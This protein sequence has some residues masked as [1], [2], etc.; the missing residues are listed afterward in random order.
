MEKFRTD[1][2]EGYTTQ[3]LEE[4]NDRLNE[5]LRKH[6]LAFYASVGANRNIADMEDK[7]LIDQ[8]AE[9]IQATYD[10]EHLARLSA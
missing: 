1:N 7:A 4:L 3:E 10:S 2:T 8:I 9:R 5:E 6:G